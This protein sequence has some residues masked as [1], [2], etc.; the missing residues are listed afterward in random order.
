M[1]CRCCWCHRAVLRWAARLRSTPGPYGTP[2]N[3]PTATNRKPGYVGIAAQQVQNCGAQILDVR[4]GSPA[5]TAKLLVG[6]IVVAVDGQ[7]IT[8]LDQFRLIVQNHM[9]GDKVVITI[10]RGKLQLD[11]TV[12]LT[13]PAGSSS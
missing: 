8:S 3:K 5:E 4:P 10:E 1:A 13:V 11:A 7:P 6:D 9:A 2:A 12:T